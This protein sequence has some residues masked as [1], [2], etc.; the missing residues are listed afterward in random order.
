MGN[1]IIP[2]VQNSRPYDAASI[3]RL[4]KRKA[5]MLTTDSLTNSKCVCNGT[6]YGTEIAILQ[7]HLHLWSDCLET[8][9]TS[10]SFC[11]DLPTLYMLNS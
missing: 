2:V 4:S 8:V 6:S 5:V 3:S 11:R 10:K 9:G 1:R 7:P